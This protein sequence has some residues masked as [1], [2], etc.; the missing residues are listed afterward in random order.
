MPLAK[1]SHVLQ[2][3][4]IQAALSSAGRFLYQRKTMSNEHTLV[5]WKGVVTQRSAVVA[6]VLAGTLSLSDFSREDLLQARS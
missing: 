1:E 6:F 3:H 2:V 5:V 4:S